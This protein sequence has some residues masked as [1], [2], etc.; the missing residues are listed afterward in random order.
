MT[1]L[2]VNH[3]QNN[4]DHD[5][6]TTYSVAKGEGLDAQRPLLQIDIIIVVG[7]VRIELVGN[8]LYYGKGPAYSYSRSSL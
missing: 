4:V 6:G 5:A 3:L 8:R 1:K 2:L 7:L